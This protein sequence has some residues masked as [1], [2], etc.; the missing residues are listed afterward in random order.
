[1]NYRLEIVLNNNYK[2]EKYF[3]FDGANMI[4]FNLEKKHPILALI[5]KDV[6]N[7]IDIFIYYK[8]SLILNKKNIFIQEEELYQIYTFEKKKL[9]CHCIEY[10][11]FIIG[12][13]IKE[14]YGMKYFKSI[15]IFKKEII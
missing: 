7:V 9:Y 3:N 10:N 14:Y 1:M 12:I 6:Q 2:F 5:C 11:D 4:I 15:F 13:D 8:E